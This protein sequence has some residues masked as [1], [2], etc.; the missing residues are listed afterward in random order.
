MNEKNFKLQKMHR[1]RKNQSIQNNKFKKVDL[2]KKAG[3]Y[4]KECFKFIAWIRKK[5]MSE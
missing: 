3:H 4:K 5:T 2:R 1:N